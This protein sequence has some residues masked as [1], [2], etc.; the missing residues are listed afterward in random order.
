MRQDIMSNEDVDLLNT[1]VYANLSPEEKAEFTDA[2]CLCPTNA[3]VDQINLNRLASSNNPVLIVPALHTGPGAAKR[4]EDDAEGL[5]KKLLLMEGAKV[6]V[7][8][9]LWTSQGLTNGTMGVIR[10]NPCKSNH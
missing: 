1:R 8:R 2:L 10:I 7:T 9:N 4:S 6:M 5:E 3:L